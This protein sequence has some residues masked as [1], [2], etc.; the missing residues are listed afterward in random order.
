MKKIFL[1]LWF[2]L[3]GLSKVQAYEF[4]KNG[5][6]YDIVK[7]KAVVVRNWSTS[8]T[9]DV[10][11][12]DSVEYYG[13]YYVVDS[14]GEEAFNSCGELTSVRLPEG[15]KNIG[16]GTF[17]LCSGLTSLSF[18][19]GLISIG[20]DAFSNC[21]GL[22]SLS[23]PEG[24]TEI[25]DGAFAGC[26]GLTS[27]SFPNGLISIGDNAF[28]GCS[29]LTS[30]SFPEGMTEIGFRAFQRCGRWE[31]LSFPSTMKSIDWRVF[32]EYHA[33]GGYGECTCGSIKHIEVRDILTWCNSNRFV[34]WDHYVVASNADLYVDGELLTDVVL[35]DT[36]TRIRSA[37]FYGCK[38]LHSVV[39]PKNLKV[40]D[41]YAFS[42]CIGIENLEFP[43]GLD[44]IKSSAFSG[45]EGL[46]S[47]AFPEG[48]TAVGDGAFYGC[49]KLD[50]LS[51]PASMKAINWTAFCTHRGNNGNSCSCGHIRYVNVK[52]LH[53]WINS[54]RNVEFEYGSPHL[55]F[56]KAHLYMGGKLLT[57]VVIPGDVTEVKPYTFSGMDSI[58]TV[59]MQ[60]GVENVGIS[61]FSGCRNLSSVSFSE[62]LKE[63]SS[64]AFENC[65]S[66][67]SVSFSEGLEKIDSYAFENCG[68]LT[69]VVFPEGL[70]E[71]EERTFYGCDKLD[72]LS[73][74]A[75]MKA[76]NWTAFCTHKGNYGNSCSCEHIR[77][78]DV[79]DLHTWINSVRY[80][81]SEY[82]YSHLYFP[83]AHL[84]VRGKL[85]THVVIQGDVT[86]VKPYTFSGMDNIR[87]VS[88]QK[89]V[90][91]VGKQAF[92]DCRN[93]S[94]VS[95]S[96][97]LKE[98]SS[99]A[100]E[101]CASLT[102]VAFPEGLT[103]IGNA[104]FYGCDKLDSLSFPTSMKAINWTAFCTHKGNY[105][106]SC[107]CEHIR[108]VDVKDLHT[109]INS[110][111]YVY[112]EY[113][114]SHLYFPKAHLY[115]GGKLLTHAVI[116]SDIA[117]VKP[118]T[119][120]GMDSIRTVSMQ[121]GV[122][123]VGKLAFSGCRNLSSVSFSEGLKEISSYAFENC[124]SLSS[125]TFS[126]G[127]EEI[128]ERAF[129]G[130]DSLHSVKLPA[131]IKK[132]GVSAFNN[133]G[134]EFQLYALVPPQRESNSLG[135]NLVYVPESCI[136]A[137][138]TAWS[139]KVN[140][141]LCLERQ[142]DWDV[143]VEAEEKS[144]AVLQAVGG[145][146]DNEAAR[147]VVRLKVSGT[148]NSYDF[149]VMRN[150]M[151]SLRELDL[152]DA[153]VVYNPYEH[154]QGYHS[155]NDSLPDYA[156][157]RKDLRVCKLPQSITY[158]GQSAFS[159]CRKL[160]GMDI[161]EKVQEI[162]YAAFTGCNS[163]KEVEFHEGL[164]RIG[165]DAFSNCALQDTIVFPQTLKH[166]SYNAFAMNGSL[167]AVKF[168]V[169]LESIEGSAFNNCSGLSE[170]RFPA[171]VL[172]VGSD[173]FVMC[174]NIKDVY[175]YIIDPF[176]LDQN[177]FTAGVFLKA[178]LHVPETAQ[179]NYYWNTQ[180][181]QFQGRLVTFNEPYEYFYLNK[182]LVIDEETPRLEGDTISGTG[183]V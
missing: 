117:E 99:Y 70:T 16:R 124:A 52:D 141:I 94:S 152:T 109:W 181:S 89:G 108:Y 76:I 95:L 157:Y 54:V 176:D 180:W 132:I 110:V 19:N 97:G 64:Y 8:Y 168:P 81:D 67:S 175:T 96:E 105:G 49:D 129:T 68:S 18:P 34:K 163:L 154:Y 21:S 136:E 104:A 173:A 58:R 78:V 60:K 31:A 79:K 87:T 13:H 130:C 101:N 61:A 27:L 127:F 165:D 29:G 20:G 158:I 83:K 182:D 50:S 1:L 135:E 66:L 126:E 174:D 73:F 137:Y 44:S 56:S 115:T 112:S 178:T 131:S 30:L 103:E 15:L 145:V 139:D 140:D 74:P 179:D 17:S 59:S 171:S 98:I 84:Y 11:I 183:E 150:K 159:E 162:G 122:E 36:L 123:N 114:Y 169:G 51:F 46:T 102:S 170:V 41:D 72:S 138:R 156:F 45:C 53:T 164:E 118:Y 77:Y 32:C 148:V 47:I 92:S 93:L 7:D 149:M 38:K 119:F 155:W 62:G 48:L 71:I 22:T 111:R 3:L 4:E 125:V 26:S 91:N 86:E 5:I 120:S 143:T 107:S 6:Y 10:V 37:L 151:T 134:V 144:S 12:P 106:N 25:G 23:F 24:M 82:G 35:P 85:L 128:G 9:G 116:P 147:N 172:S 69:S 40:I 75:S 57:H 80:L 55:Y 161:P 177:T 14:I 43:R 167:K 65:E 160:T 28:E 88:M 153:H 100:F 2:V 42:G 142:H 121:K 146:S 63:I 33:D 133:Q 39:F 113:G 90:E 166:I